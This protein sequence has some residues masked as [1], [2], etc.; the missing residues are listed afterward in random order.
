MVA[1][2]RFE[3]A[4][5][6]CGG[7]ISAQ[8]VGP[9]QFAC[10]YCGWRHYADIP[11]RSVK[12]GRVLRLPYVGTSP[13]LAYL[14]PLAVVMVDGVG[15]EPESCIGLRIACPMCRQD[16]ALSVMKGRDRSSERWRC[17]VGHVV[18]LH[19]IDREEIVGWS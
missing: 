3:G 4:C 16:G 9:E 17:G 19:R 18:R 1:E 12:E 2:F 6:R 5:S 11:L 15:G 8:V 10:I 7:D 13:R 14:P